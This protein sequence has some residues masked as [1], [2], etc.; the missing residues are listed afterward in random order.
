MVPDA[1]SLVRFIRT[2][3]WNPEE[4]RPKSSLFKATDQKLSLFHIVRVADIGSDIDELRFG[5]LE[6]AGQAIMRA[7]V[8][9]EEAKKCNT[10]V[11]AEVYFRPDGV[12]CRWCADY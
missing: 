10:E 12:G 11:D 3:D 4:K 8:Y 5:S 6:G 2:E 9:R 7:S 1:D